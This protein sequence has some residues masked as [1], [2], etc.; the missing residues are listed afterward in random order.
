MEYG[1]WSVKYRNKGEGE[2]KP[3]LEEPGYWY[4]DPMLFKMDGQIY[5]FTEAF[6][7]RSQIGQIAVSKYENGSF[8]KPHVIIKNQYHMSYPC[9]FQYRNKVYM[10]PETSQNGTLE[11]YSP[12]GSI[13][14]PWKKIAILKSGIKLVD[15]TVCIANEEVYLIGYIENSK[16]Y[17]TKIY[18]VDM[19]NFRLNELGSY[20]HKENIYRPGGNII[21]KGGKYLRPLQF[22]RNMYGEKLQIAEFNPLENIWLGI[23]K[24]EM[25]VKDFS[26]FDKYT[27]IHTIAELDEVTV[28]DLYAEKHTF[29]NLYYKVRRKARNAVYKI[30]RGEK[31]L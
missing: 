9:T 17:V 24:E 19:I 21:I 11:I 3:L 12:V 7:M 1:Y 31:I 27:R 30:K 14:D 29:L 2:W 20:E 23:I 8:T 10:I 18:S 13:L 16:Q 5:L 6:K 28:I 4:A 25:T 26:A 22:N 15:S